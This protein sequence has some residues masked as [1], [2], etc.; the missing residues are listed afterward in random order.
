M[1]KTTTKYGLTYP[2]GTD[3]PDIA[4]WTKALADATEAALIAQGI[5]DTGWVLVPITDAR[6]VPYAAGTEPR[7]RVKNGVCTFLGEIK[8]STAG[9]IDSGLS[10]ATLP[11]EARPGPVR[12][13]TVQQGS[14]DDR[15][16]LAITTGGLVSAERW[17]PST[18]PAGV[19]LPFSATW[20]VG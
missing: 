4:Y 15:W 7:Y 10:W 20:V 8:T 13:V 19:W 6:I 16:S 9:L 17:G 14:G 5:S 2:E 12:V 11:A 3:V 18:S 1:S